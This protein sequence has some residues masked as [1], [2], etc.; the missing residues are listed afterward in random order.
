MSFQHEEVLQKVAAELGDELRET[1][2]VAENRLREIDR[3]QQE[4]D[5]AKN[6]LREV[7]VKARLRE[8]RGRCRPL[9]CFLTI[10]LCFRRFAGS[11][12]TP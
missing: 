10:L 6:E 11:S 9:E 5:Q 1:K 3:I 4:L 8:G 12:A 2:A 7:Q